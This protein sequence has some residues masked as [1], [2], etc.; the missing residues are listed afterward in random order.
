MSHIL[1][2]EDDPDLVALLSHHLRRRGHE[3][4][5]AFD[6]SEGY[7]AA[8]RN[9]PDVVVLDLLLP[10]FTGHEVLHLIRTNP[11]I[12]RT[13]VLVLSA[14]DSEE[15]KSRV[16]ARGADAAIGKPFSLSNVLDRIADLLRPRPRPRSG[17]AEP[18]AL[19]G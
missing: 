2:I 18:I 8:V 3:V 9:R 1:L 10:G 19:S 16:R 6:G 5:V 12:R 13:P 11:E 15:E 17:S 14:L 7:V 4:S